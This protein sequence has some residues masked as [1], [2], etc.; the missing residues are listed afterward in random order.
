[1]ADVRSQHP[2]ALFD[3]EMLVGEEDRAIRDTVRQVVD[4][5]VRFGVSTDG[6]DDK[7]NGLARRSLFY[8]GV[9]GH[10]WFRRGH[11]LVGIRGGT[12]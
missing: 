4:E 11:R 10:S 5:K 1:M 9:P 2:L 8:S 3:V 12:S 6:G 7:D